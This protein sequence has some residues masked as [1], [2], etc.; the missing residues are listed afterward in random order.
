MGWWI[1]IGVC[2]VI[3]E[4]LVLRNYSSAS[5]R[6]EWVGSS[7]FLFWI[8]GAILAGKLIGGVW[9][10]I[11]GLL[12]GVI[13]SISLMADKQAHKLYAALLP[14]FA[15]AGAIFS[16][17]YLGGR[18]WNIALGGIAGWVVCYLLNLPFLNKVKAEEERKRLEEE[19]YE[20]NLPIEEK[21]ARLDSMAQKKLQETSAELVQ[22][23]N[24]YTQIAAT[25]NG[26]PP[27]KMLEEYMN[28]G[29]NVFKSSLKDAFVSS[30]VEAAEKRVNTIREITN[31]YVAA[32]RVSSNRAKLEN[33]IYTYNRKKALLFAERI[34]EIYEKLTPKQKERKIDDAAKTL[35]IGGRNIFIPDTLRNFRVLSTQ[36]SKRRK[37]DEKE[38][39]KRQKNFNKRFKK[40]IDATDIASTV[41]FYGGELIDGAVSKYQ[42]SKE[43]KQELQ[44][45]EMEF[46]KRIGEVEEARLQED[47]FTEQIGEF[48]RAL[49]GTMD[50]YGKMF[51]EIHTTLYPP[52]DA[53]KSKEA[54]EKNKENGGTYFS[55]EEADAVLELRTTG[56][57][58]LNQ[59]DTELEGD[60]DE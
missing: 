26:S 21:I 14:F 46:I 32:Y 6:S 22:A 17:Q 5:K 27:Q 54:R 10:V 51:V 40:E 59:V 25:Y 19:E 53:S 9:W 16:Y 58:L 31:Y 37:V 50:A 43:L 13:V 57:L 1:A 28:S 48:N 23:N 45:A 20:R 41:I 55:D 3:H 56:Q 60:D 18:W 2:V 12:V 11:N 35:N 42:D 49:E 33:D 39:V 24:Q 15:A 47:A 4:V 29:G 34:K 7:I 38:S 36:L 30:G 8:I 44:R 52:G